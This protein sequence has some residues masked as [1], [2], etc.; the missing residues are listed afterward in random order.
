MLL[1][2]AVLAQCCRAVGEP[3]EAR[4]HV[5]AVARLHAAGVAAWANDIARRITGEG[6]AHRG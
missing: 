6:E 3:D 5:E 4:A 2:H 1:A